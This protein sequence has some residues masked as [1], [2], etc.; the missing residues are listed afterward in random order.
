VSKNYFPSSWLLPGL[1]RCKCGARFGLAPTGRAPVLLRFSSAE[2]SSDPDSSTA[3]CFCR[4]ARFCMF[5]SSVWSTPDQMTFQGHPSGICS[6]I[7]SIKA[8]S[9][10]ESFSRCSAGK[11]RPAIKPTIAPPSIA[12]SNRTFFMTASSFPRYPRFSIKFICPYNHR[13]F[14]CQSQGS[15]LTFFIIGRATFFPKLL[16][17]FRRIVTASATS[18]THP[19]AQ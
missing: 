5:C 9:R 14:N 7:P 13:A 12:I 15:V 6:T 11:R 2:D 17:S 19:R 16:E 3:G 10:R 4:R 1:S 18:G 8:A